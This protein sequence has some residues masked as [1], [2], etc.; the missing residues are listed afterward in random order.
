MKPLSLTV[1][2]FRFIHLANIPQEQGRRKI[3]DSCL[4]HLDETQKVLL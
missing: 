3:I 4:L 1:C 2:S